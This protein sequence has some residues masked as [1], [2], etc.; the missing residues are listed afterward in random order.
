MRSLTFT[1]I[2]TEQTTDAE[3]TD[4]EGAGTDRIDYNSVLDI[5]LQRKRS[6]ERHV[7][8]KSV[9]WNKWYPEAQQQR[10]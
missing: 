8:L 7:L 6:N 5:F 9:K 10:G 1:L 3:T 4:D 2:R